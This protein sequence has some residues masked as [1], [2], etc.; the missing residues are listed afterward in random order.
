MTDQETAKDLRFTKILKEPI[1]LFAI[2]A[3]SIVVGLYFFQFRNKPLS[4][5]NEH[6]GTFGDFV[7]G[8]LNPIFSFLGL[9]ALLFTIR[10]QS[11]EL[12]L[13][14]K[15][16]E[17][18]RTELEKSAEAQK[19]TE[20]LLAEQTKTQLI[21]QFEGTFFSL[22]NQLNRI[23]E[24]TT[25]EQIES[26][27]E[28]SHSRKNNFFKKPQFLYPSTLSKIKNKTEDLDKIKESLTL[29][30]EKIKKELDIYQYLFTLSR[31]LEFM[32]IHDENINMDI[33]SR[34]LQSLIPPSGGV[35]L[36]INTFSVDENGEFIF[37]D[38]KMLIEKYSIL[39]FIDIPEYQ[40]NSKIFIT[41]FLEKYDQKAFG[42]NQ[43]YKKLIA[44]KEDLVS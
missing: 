23:F 41:Y 39:E 5:L 15:E 1:S 10:L 25:S 6:W 33:Y 9:M 35:F 42:S 32:R 7:G 8:V 22:L 16:L 19:G 11:Q 26:V 31:I 43:N 17:L 3:F 2:L 28:G 27:Y 37:N 29:F 34:I 40:D 18:T 21:Q 44:P 12:A 4:L 14:R 13:T 24:V 38:I 30:K 36:A 20:K